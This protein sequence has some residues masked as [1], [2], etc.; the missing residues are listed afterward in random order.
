MDFNLTKQQVAIRDNARAV[1]QNH[2]CTQKIRGWEKTCD[3]TSL[4]LWNEVV[5]NGWSRL[6]LPASFGGIGGYLEFCVFLEE[7]GRSGASLPFVSCLGI[8][9]TI[10]EYSPNGSFRNLYLQEIAEGKIIAPALIDEKS[11]NEW[12]TGNLPVLFSGDEYKL[13]GRKIL[14]PFGRSADGFIVTARTP[15]DDFAILVVDSS[16]DGI[17]IVPH[18]T[19]I[20][21]PLFWIEFT[22]VLVSH[23][24]IIN[25]GKD[26]EEAV[27]SALRKGALLATSEAV[28]LCE[29]IKNL[30]AEYVTSRHAFGKPIGSFQAVAHPCAD[31]H[32][33]IETI[34]ILT[35]QAAWML[36]TGKVATE[37]IE[38]TK[39]LAN[40]LFERLANDA[41]CMH[42][43]QGYAEACDLQIFLR[44]IRGFCATIGETHE[45][46]ERAAQAINL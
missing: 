33:R 30:S 26:A 16:F 46:F 45:S 10:L 35:Q 42:G 4:E 2:V 23:D 27:R 28:G 3:G 24:R 20:G 19:E 18:K 25:T 21:V 36:D 9:A 39:A 1:L 12:D 7:L 17:S 34:R 6:S 11:R 40:E 29:T 37:E 5:K 43:A 38:S 22:D 31:M 14:V 13:S 32:I 41:F 44:R 15:D 8:S